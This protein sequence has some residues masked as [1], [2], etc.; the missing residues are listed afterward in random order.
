M[1]RNS[2]RYLVVHGAWTPPGMDIGVETIRGW[3][4]K[5]EFDDVGYHYVIRRD[6]IVENGR[7][8]G[9]VGAHV[10]GYNRGSV[11]ICLIGGKPAAADGVPEDAKDWLW[12]FNYTRPQMVG[13]EKL[14]TG[15]K[16][17]YPEAI[18]LGHTDFPDVDKLCPG[19]NVRAWWG[20]EDV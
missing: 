9:N 18:I 8:L 6:G 1:P 3:H 14:L 2:T 7:P 19:F 17:L 4:L 11:G 20:A 12:E 10:R 13:L 16:K 15:L 5:R